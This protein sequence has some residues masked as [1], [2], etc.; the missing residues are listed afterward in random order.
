[1]TKLPN[2]LI[3]LNLYGERY[4]ISLSFI[5]NFTDL[6]ELQLSFGNSEYFKTFKQ[7]QYAIF[8]QLQIL[9]IRRACPRWELLIKF[10]ESN[11]KNLKEFYVCDI[12]GISDNS[13]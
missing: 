13:L 6:Q 9:K 3:K 4:Y 11:G 5:G 8:P 12:N 2:N 1:M 10:L 7:L